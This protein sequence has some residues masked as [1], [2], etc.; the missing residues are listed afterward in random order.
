MYTGPLAA[1]SNRADLKF[2]VEVVDNDT[3]DDIDLTDSTINVALREQTDSVNATPVLTGSTSDG[4]VTLVSDGTFQVAF[5]PSDMGAL[6]AGTYD[7]GI[8]VKL[9][10]GVT[11]QLLA[12]TLPVIDGIVQ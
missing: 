10:T 8:T 9:S 3:G 1:A 5:T 2:S 6:K 12:G 7:I 4:K 11:F